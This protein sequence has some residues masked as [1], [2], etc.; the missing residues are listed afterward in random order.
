M[1]FEEYE[2]L[3][4]YTLRGLFQVL[5]MKKESIDSIKDNAKKEKTL[6]EIEEI[7]FY[8]DKMIEEIH[9]NL[10]QQGIPKSNN[11]KVFHLLKKK[12]IDILQK[13]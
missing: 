2:K 10:L 11:K 6:K 5:E 13:V 9:E 1:T 7:N 4:G 12:S 8:I 3:K